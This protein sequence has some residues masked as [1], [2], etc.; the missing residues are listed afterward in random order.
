MKGLD[1]LVQSFSLPEMPVKYGI[2]E[3]WQ[4]RIQVKQDG[5]RLKQNSKEKKR[6][7]GCCFVGNRPFIDFRSLQI[8]GLQVSLFTI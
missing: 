6:F 1:R 4:T 5:D 2:I 3:E 8:R 7:N